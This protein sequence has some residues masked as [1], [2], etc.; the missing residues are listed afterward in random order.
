MP[1]QKTHSGAKKRFRVTRNGKVMV[2]RKNRKHLLEKKSAS[3]K[4]RLQGEAELAPGDA[5][6]V[7][8]LLNQ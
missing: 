5:A 4:R 8:R 3:R 1:K 6:K 2:R 7:K